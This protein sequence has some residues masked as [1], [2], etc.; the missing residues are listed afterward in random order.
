MAVA[1][2]SMSVSVSIVTVRREVDRLVVNSL[3]N[4]VHFALHLAFTLLQQSHHVKPMLSR[5]FFI[6]YPPFLPMQ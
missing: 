5:D 3:L 4:Q 6:V 1:S 2:V